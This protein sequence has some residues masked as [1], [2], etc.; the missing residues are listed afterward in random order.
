VATQTPKKT[1]RDQN[2]TPLIACFIAIKTLRRPNAP[3]IQ[4]KNNLE[5]DRPK[6]TAS[7]VKFQ[8]QQRIPKEQNMTL[9]PLNHT[10]T[11]EEGLNRIA[12]LCS[13]ASAALSAPQLNKNALEGLMDLLEHGEDMA[14]TIRHLLDVSVLNQDIDPAA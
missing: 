13:V 10:L 5:H 11:V 2:Q 7:A 12:R 6:P 1:A 3:L 8:F 4:Q 9:T 14:D